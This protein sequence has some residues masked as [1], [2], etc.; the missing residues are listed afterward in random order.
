VFL[1]FISCA[2]HSHVVPQ[3]TSTWFLDGRD[4]Q[5]SYVV[6]ASELARVLSVNEPGED[7]SRWL[8]R[9]LVTRLKVSRDGRDCSL[10]GEPHF[11]S[12]LGDR[13]G[14]ISLSFACPDTGPYE[15][16]SRALFDVS[17]SHTHLARVFQGGRLVAEFAFTRGHETHPIAGN[18]ISVKS[19]WASLLAQFVI[20]GISHILSGPDHLAFLVGLLLIS[21]TWR[22]VAALTGGF[23]LGH[24]VTLILAT[25]D[26][27]RPH[28]EVVECLVAFTVLL[29]AL[30]A[31][32]QRVCTVPM[33][34]VLCGIV[35]ATAAGADLLVGVGLAR[36]PLYGG[37]CL[38]ASGFL[39]LCSLFPESSNVVQITIACIF[40]LVH[41]MAFASG[42]QE[43][44]IIG[45][46]L[47]P[48]LA[49]FNVGVEIGQL[50]FLAVALAVA[51][52]L[53]RLADVETI[54]KISVATSLGLCTIAAWWFI[55]R[56]IAS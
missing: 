45:S 3:S 20:L 23:T 1:L 15:L 6:P 47:V 24:S 32:R 34:I 43:L 42:L 17:P 4:V 26:R 12:D 19:G 14:T 48:A 52:G 13:N 33:A 25:T 8:T 31:L 50:S 18:S 37:L 10:V 40:G 5:M 35:V 49:G 56:I 38:I 7:E 54:S 16:T 11:V 2:A 55:D 41:G 22:R 46:A 29:V 36:M 39:L 21:H 53:R 51:A 44:Q 9:Y 27:I 30:D 28:A